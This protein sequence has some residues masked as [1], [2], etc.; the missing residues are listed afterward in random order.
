MRVTCVAIEA[1]ELVCVIR[2]LVALRAVGKI[3]DQ[4]YQLYPRQARYLL[5]RGR[6]CKYGKEGG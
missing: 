3:S 4:T 2:R 5:I 1:E 6:I